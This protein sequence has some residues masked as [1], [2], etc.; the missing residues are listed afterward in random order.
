MT[1]ISS[2]AGLG[3]ERDRQR[4]DLGQITIGVVF[5]V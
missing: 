4:H 5:D 1:R 2:Y 3:R